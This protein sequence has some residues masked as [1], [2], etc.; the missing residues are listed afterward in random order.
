MNTASHAARWRALA[1][2]SAIFGAGVSV[3]LLVEYTTGQAGVCLTGSGCDEVRASE[4]A[5]PLGIPMPLFGVVFYSV[6]AWLAYRTLRGGPI[7]GI[8]LRTL[9]LLA[10]FAG[11]AMSAALTAIEAFVIESFCTWCLAS[12]AAS[13]L[14]MVGAI[15]LWR[16]PDAEPV[17]GTSGRARQQRARAES[18]ERDSLQRVTLWGGAA[19]AV[20]VSVLLAAGAVAGGPG[21]SEGGDELAPAGSPRLGG[22][23]VTVVEF[24]D[25]QCPACAVVGPMLQEM[26]AANEMTLVFRHFPLDT[27]HANASS[28][29]WAAEAAERQ[30]AFYGM[31][32]ALY[33]TQAAWSNLGP[34]DAEAYFASLAE[35]LGLDVDQWRADYTSQEVRSD[36]AADADAAR[37][38]NLRGT[39]T[40]YVGGE[41]Y[42]GERSPSAIRGA[43]AAAAARQAESSSEG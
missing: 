23:A 26:A 35:Q 28:S 38:L 15:G 29:S 27:I 37:E 2:L 21:P 20:L 1:L 30:G 14:L 39:P 13:L 5:Y 32:E 18:V 33:A 42:E 11:L 43:I 9:L 25:F 19:T 22:G 4:F 40:I 17:S 31:A 16:T 10:G 6:S 36:V 41:L 3:Y 34:A 24:A 8:P 12:A 7:L